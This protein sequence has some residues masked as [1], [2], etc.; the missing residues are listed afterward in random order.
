MTGF[1][2]VCVYILFVCTVRGRQSARQNPKWPG[3]RRRVEKAK[4]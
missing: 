1:E 3:R 2:C 4:S